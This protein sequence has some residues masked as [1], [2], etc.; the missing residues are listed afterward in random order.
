MP[1]AYDVLE[2]EL[3]AAVNT[4]LQQLT[5]HVDPHDLYAAG[6][7]TCGELLYLAPTANT[8]SALATS[9]CS[10][11]SPPDWALHLSLHEVFQPV[12]DVLAGGWT[13]D[14]ETFDIDEARVRAIIHDVLR[15]ARQ[16]HFKGTPTVM[17]LFMGGMGHPWV[18]AS[19]QAI[20]PG[21][22]ARAFTLT[23]FAH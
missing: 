9:K 13:T 4:W 3:T 12:E 11:W 8:R 14:F 7:Y 19:V 23:T 10:P 20:N 5:R 2:A 1:V 17:G 15:S 6:L 21:D 18:Q 16:Q 22:V